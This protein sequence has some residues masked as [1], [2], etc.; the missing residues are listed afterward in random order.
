MQFSEIDNYITSRYTSSLST[1]DRK[2]HINEVYLDLSRVFT[3]D[4]TEESA[5]LSTVVAQN[6]V[7]MTFAT[8]QIKHIHT[9]AAGV[10]TPLRRI[11]QEAIVYPVTSGKPTRWAPFGNTQVVGANRAQVLLNPTPNAIINLVIAYEPVPANLSLDADVPKYIPEGYHHLIAWGSIAILASNQEDW[12]VAQMWE[13]RFRSGVN[14][15]IATLGLNAPENFPSL[16]MA[17]QR[18]EGKANV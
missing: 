6:V 16:A 11:M 1:A 5:A 17:V 15:M 3:P 14:E 13:A 12:D 4:I 7:T 8:R 9:S 10:R 2:A 18:Q